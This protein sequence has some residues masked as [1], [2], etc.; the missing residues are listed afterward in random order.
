MI[1]NYMDYSYDYCMNIFTQNQKDRMLVVMD[2][3]PRR[4]TLKNSTK[5]QPIPLFANDAEVKVEASCSTV[6]PVCI[7]SLAGSQKVTI[8]NRGTNALTAVTLNY[9]VDGGNNNTYNLSLIHI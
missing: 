3:S 6:N 9:A 4:L 8:F 1:E 2:N 7:T 5:D